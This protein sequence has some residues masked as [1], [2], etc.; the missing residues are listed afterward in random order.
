M[1]VLLVASSGGHLAPLVWMKP[2]WSAHERRW[3]T[4]DT[5]DARGWL[6]GEDVV[7]AF[8]PTNRH[9]GN[10]AR[11]TRLARRALHEFRPRLVVSTG[12]AL[13]VPFFAFS[14]W[15]GA[16]TV[17][18]EAYDRVDGPSLT[19]RLVRPLADRIV[20]QHEVQRTFY[21]TGVVLG[22]VR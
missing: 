4:F 13:A 8:H 2:W 19:G 9:L 6:A 5:A 16:K 12:A 7:W 1:K 10:L 18:I 3:V 14:R 22:P 15:Y 20:L 11:N 21:P 17:F